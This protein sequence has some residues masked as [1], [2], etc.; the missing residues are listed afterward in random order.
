MITTVKFNIGSW[1]LSPSLLHTFVWTKDFVHVFM[2]MI[3]A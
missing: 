1:S 2:K 3:K